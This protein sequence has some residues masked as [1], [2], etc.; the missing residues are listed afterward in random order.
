MVMAT[1]V[2][3]LAPFPPVPLGTYGT[4]PVPLPGCQMSFVVAVAV[5]GLH[6][7][8]NGAKVPRPLQKREK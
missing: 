8:R 7:T 3:A 2:P 6:A 1:T 4:P 5:G